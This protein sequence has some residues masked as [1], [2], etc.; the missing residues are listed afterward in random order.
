MNVIGHSQYNEDQIIKLIFND[1]IAKGSFF[2]I[3]NGGT[4]H[5]SM[6][7]RQT[8]RGGLVWTLDRCTFFTSRDSVLY[9]NQ[10]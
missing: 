8:E 6:Q 9:R 2:E 4:T 7:Y 10:K 1:K 3:N 5:T